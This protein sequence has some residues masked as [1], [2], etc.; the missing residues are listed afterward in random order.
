MR[1]ILRVKGIAILPVP[2]VTNRTRLSSRR[3]ASIDYLAK[4]EQLKA[5]PLRPPMRASDTLTLC[6]GFHDATA[7][8][9]R[10][11]MSDLIQCL[12]SV[13]SHLLIHSF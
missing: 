3:D 11:A 8:R 13:G 4:Y 9:Q 7:A 12:T 5:C 6:R 2:I 1:R 10:E